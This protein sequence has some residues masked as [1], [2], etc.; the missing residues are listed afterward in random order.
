VAVTAQEAFEA[1]ACN[2]VGNSGTIGTTRV[3]IS[4]TTIPPVAN[5]PMIDPIR[6]DRVDSILSAEDMSV[7]T[8]MPPSLPL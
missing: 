6:G 8:M 2:S 4:D 1:E 7:D 3:C 5:T